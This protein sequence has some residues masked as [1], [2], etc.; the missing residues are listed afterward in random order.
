MQVASSDTERRWAAWRLDRNRR[1]LR[2]ALWLVL[3]L[4]PAFGLLDVLIAPRAALPSLLG[5]RLAVTVISIALFRIVR[6]RAF[7]AN[8]DLISSAYIVLGASVIS[9]MTVYM[10][11]LASPY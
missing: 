10:G 1:G 11:G 4:Y 5:A 8:A 2:T 3:L 9:Y 6:T 7:E